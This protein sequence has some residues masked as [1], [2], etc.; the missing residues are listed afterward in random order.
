[1]N[2]GFRLWQ[3]CHRCQETMV[4]KSPDETPGRLTSALLLKTKM[5]AAYRRE[6]PEP[7]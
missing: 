2:E 3:G 4:D 7:C 5:F 6:E 1:M